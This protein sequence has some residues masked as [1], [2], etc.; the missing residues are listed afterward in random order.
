MTTPFREELVV[1]DRDGDAAAEARASHTIREFGY[2]VGIWIAGRVVR[3]IGVGSGYE[4][5]EDG[6]M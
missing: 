4:W 5:L 3:H 6:R 2:I 1:L